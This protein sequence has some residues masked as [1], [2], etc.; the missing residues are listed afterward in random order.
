MFIGHYAPALALHRARPSVPLWVLFVAAQAVDV[1]W[2]VFVLTGVEHARMVPGFTSSNSLDLYDMPYSHGLLA[3][4]VWSVGL[5][6]L[7]R[8]FRPPQRRGGEALIV[9]LAV[10]SHFLLDL[11]VHVPD[12]PVVGTDGPKWGLGLW[13]HREVALLVECA[14]F[15]VAA[16]VWRQAREIRTPRSAIV[17]GAMTAFLVASY[18]LPAP[19]MPA[20]MAVSGLGT[21]AACALSAWWMTAPSARRELVH[22]V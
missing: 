17:F 8:A 2:G 7:W 6:L 22:F 13:R 19:P 5:A 4:V 18:Y 10:A 9:G 21:Y 20:A 1:I 12:L 16:L 3:T 11:V 14:I 15:V